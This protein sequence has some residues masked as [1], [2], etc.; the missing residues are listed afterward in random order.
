[1]IPLH[2]DN[3]THIRPVVTVSFITACVL[4]FFWQISLGSG[5][6]QRIVYSLGVIPV[7]L[8][9]E[10]ELPPELALVPPEATLITSMFLHGGL[11]HLAGNMLFLW[12]FGN[13]IEDSM[14]HGRFVIF[15]LLCGIGAALTQAFIYP[16]SEV[17]M[18]GASG[19]I[20]GVLG[21][22][23]LLYPHARVLVLIPLGFFLQLVRLPAVWVLGLW[24]VFQ[25]LSSALADTS[26]GG[27]AFFAHIGGFVA[28]MLLIAAFKRR[29]VRFFQPGHGSRRLSRRFDR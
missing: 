5:G 27:V 1:M 22:Y 21:A 12:I 10:A 4:I 15:Y 28:G 9:G 11:M 8:F 24:F 16:D 19:A 17:P 3:P 29:S 23:L 14:G 20:S 18:I 25:L 6:Y 13:N 26:G 7:V 2:D